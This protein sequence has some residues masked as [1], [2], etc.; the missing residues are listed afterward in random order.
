MHLRAFA[1]DHRHLAPAS[2]FA[3]GF[4]LVL[5]ARLLIEEHR[6]GPY[7]VGLGGILAAVSH[8]REPAHVP[9]LLRR[10]HHS[11]AVDRA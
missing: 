2:I 5:G 8:Y 3:A 4:S 9:L 6:L 10:L 7:A 11:R 1:R